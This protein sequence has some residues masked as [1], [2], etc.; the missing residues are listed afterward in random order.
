MTK[1]FGS[2]SV[3]DDAESYLKLSVVYKASAIHTPTLLAVGD[4]DQVETVLG[5]IAMYTALRYV[6][7]NVTLLRYPD[8]SHVFRGTA[9]RDLWERELRFFDAYLGTGR[10]SSEMDKTHVRE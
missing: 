2:K 1:F 4:G 10:D 6:G 8:Q 5:T 9:M 7:Q 3:F